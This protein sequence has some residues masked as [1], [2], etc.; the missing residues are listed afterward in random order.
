MYSSELKLGLPNT[1]VAKEPVVS[2]AVRRN[3][4]F[5]VVFSSQLKDFSLQ[6]PKHLLF[7]FRGLLQDK[8]E[9][10]DATQS[11]AHWIVLQQE[12]IISETAKELNEISGLV[13]DWLWKYSQGSCMQEVKH[14]NLVFSFNERLAWDHSLF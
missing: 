5:Y 2:R 3:H 1:S 12:A 8:Q 9:E 14:A 11:Q 7:V 6:S 10:L 13:N 4:Y